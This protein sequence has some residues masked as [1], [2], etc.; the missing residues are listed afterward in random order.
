MGA[1]MIDRSNARARRALLPAL[2]L[3]GAL[4]LPNAASAQSLTPM[5]GQVAAFGETF[6]L[7][8][9]PSN[10]YRHRIGVEMKVYDHQ[11]RPVPAARVVPDRF[12]LGGGASREVTAHIPFEGYSPRYVRVCAESIPYRGASTQVRTRVCG[13]FKA[14]QR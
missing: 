5:T 2:V 7:R 3:V 10:P 13:K 9:E 14:L 1:F 12:M 11:F 4:V 6:K 8:V